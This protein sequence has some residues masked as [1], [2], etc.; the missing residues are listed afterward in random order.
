MRKLSQFLFLLLVGSLLIAGNAMAISY[1][2]AGSGPLQGVLD[3]ITVGGPSSVN[4]TTD[5]IDDAY[6]TL[7]SVTGSGASNTTMIIELA[8]WATSNT[9]GIYDATNYQNTV[10]LFAGAAGSGDQ[11]TL[12]IKLDGSI[13]VNNGDTG[14]DFAGN[15]FGYYLSNGNGIFF[16]DTS[17][18]NDNVDHLAVF[19]GTDTDMVQLPNIAAGLWTDNEFV[20]AWEDVYGGGDGDYADMVLMVESVINTVPEPTTMVLLGF[21]LLGVAG[22]VRR[23]S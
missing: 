23:K 22:V 20:L 1:G 21:G 7:W 16:S 5:Y 15:S 12:S 17:L 2:S 14:I 9:F 4:V 13:H 11:V 10:Q 18:N 3:G 19:Q 8:G 6:D